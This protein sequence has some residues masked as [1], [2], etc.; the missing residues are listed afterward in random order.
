M[1]NKEIAVRLRYIG[2]LGSWADLGMFI[3]ELDSPEPSILKPGQV[4]VPRGLV[5]KLRIALIE[6][7]VALHY[8]VDDMELAATKKRVRRALEEPTGL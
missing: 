2:N 7:D 6:A 5:Q 3:D 1:T 8:P 4:A